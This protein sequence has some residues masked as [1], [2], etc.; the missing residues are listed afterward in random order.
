MVE[1]FIRATPD[2]THME[3]EWEET[4]KWVKELLIK[5]TWSLFITL[6]FVPFNF[7]AWP[8]PSISQFVNLYNFFYTQHKWGI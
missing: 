7:I 2:Y 4:V 8:L 3:K 1:D 6:M 5:Y